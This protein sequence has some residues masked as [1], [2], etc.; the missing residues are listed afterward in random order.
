MAVTF[1][2]QVGKMVFLGYVYVVC[3]LGG[4][5]KPGY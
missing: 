5:A 4:T 1:V 3:Y 2:T